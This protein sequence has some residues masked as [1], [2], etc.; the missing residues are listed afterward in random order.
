MRIRTTDIQRFRAKCHMTDLNGCWVWTA[1]K[2]KDGYGKFW[3]D[4]ATL[5]AHRVAYVIAF[6]KIPDDLCV[7]HVCDNPSCVNPSHLWAGTQAEN[8]SDKGD[9][10]RAPRGST[11]PRNKLS[12]GIVRQIMELK[13]DGVGPS[14]I[15][16][17]VGIPVGH[18][19]N[20]FYGKTWTHITG[21]PRPEYMSH[22]LA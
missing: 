12:E 21:F 13:T 9:K 8:N 14:D 10:G 20:I 17:Q 11:H 1:G 22:S 7:C 18:V 5:R 19:S 16:R 2:D 3:I 6:G 15:G 4:G